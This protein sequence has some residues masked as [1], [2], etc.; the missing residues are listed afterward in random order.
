MKLSEVT[1]QA[2]PLMAGNIDLAARPIVRNSD[3]SYS[4]VKSMS[5]GTDQGEVLV[6]TVSD[7]GRLM[8]EDE[9]I[10]QYRRTG[11]HLGIFR[12]PEEATQF[13]E[14]LH[15][16]QAA[17]YDKKASG[18]LRLSD[19]MRND[20]TAPKPVTD[21]MSTSERL[22]AGIGQGMTDVGAA[23]GQ[24]VAHGLAAEN[25]DSFMDRLGGAALRAFAPALPTLSKDQA[26]Q[27]RR[28]ADEEARNKASIDKAL[29]DTTS[30]KVGSMLGAAAATAPIGGLGGGGLVASTGKAAL[31]GAVG[32]ALST[33]ATG[34]TGVEALVSG[35]EPESFLEQKAQQAGMGAAFGAG[36][37]VALRGLGTLAERLWPSN[38][39]AQ[40]LSLVTG[41]AK[42]SAAA[43]EGAEVAKRTGV[44]L[45]PGQEMSS[46]SLKAVENAARQ[47]FWSRD[48]AAEG[49]KKRVQQ[50][51]DY[52]D[53]TLDDVTKADSSPVAMADKLRETIGSTKAGLEAI[54]RKTAAQD[55]KVV[56]DLAGNVGIVDPKALRSTLDTLIEENS[57]APKGSGQRALADSLM[58][59]KEQ[60]ADGSLKASDLLKTRRYLSQAAGGQTSLSGQLDRPMQKRA[61]SMLMGALDN[62]LDEASK[63]IGGDIGQA[64]KDANTRYRG[65]SQ[66]L[67]AL[68]N[69]PLGKILGEEFASD[70]T[71]A[72][73][74]IA[75]E[76]VVER[77]NKLKPTQIAMVKN[78]LEKESPETLQMWRRSVV[79][80]AIEKSKQFPGSAG[81]DT[82]VLRPEVL[83][84]Q[85]EKNP[86]VKALFPKGEA[87]AIA[88]GINV[89]RRLGDKTGYNFSGTA[90]QSEILNLF[91][92]PID[93]IKQG[94]NVALGGLLKTATGAF[95]TRKIAQV[96]TNP[97]A[98]E[99]LFKLQ[100]LPPGSAKARQAAAYLTA[101]YNSD[102]G[103]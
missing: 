24:I 62:D 15:D 46:D 65:F 60:V 26:E 86:A 8:T 64:L 85:L 99:A 94:G 87:Q 40:A 5:F 101:L 77:M 103:D 14:R 100:R 39:R 45:T 4:T 70:A 80:D 83:V 51:A 23:S 28:A 98:R 37:N 3:G 73:N 91:N 76:A 9:A 42:N 32:A 6:P 67:E 53:R 57:I 41:K 56:D 74:K 89:A 13:A 35:E 44:E 22:A 66:E 43:K 10:D 1:Q 82:P 90:A 58:S 20:P 68:D 12:T 72:F 7:D 48:I 54:R 47:S 69:S 49:D 81:I 92:Q 95:G 27:L 38:I 2:K 31:S 59:L 71:G 93:A 52:F 18:K 36:A 33:P 16:D 34:R 63:A 79:E 11:K 19:V 17:M 75:P 25:S 88:D 61:A 97:K 102:E 21:D 78:Y 30:G 84:T 29:L 55:Y 50:L 96:M